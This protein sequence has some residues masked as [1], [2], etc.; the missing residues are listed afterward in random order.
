MAA[1]K[2]NMQRLTV[3]IDSFMHSY[4]Q[5]DLKKGSLWVAEAIWIEW[6]RTLSNLQLP[7][8]NVTCAVH[9]ARYAKTAELLKAADSL[10][11]S[12][13]LAIVTQ[14]IELLKKV[15]VH[16]IQLQ[17]DKAQVLCEAVAKRQ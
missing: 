10:P 8:F 9:L 14:T 11:V 7:A 5:A 12:A 1:D 13:L 2:Y 6:V 16:N 17:A 15:H 4:S 3:L